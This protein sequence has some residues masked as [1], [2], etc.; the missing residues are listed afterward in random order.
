MRT[1]RID[2]SPGN[3]WGLEGEGNLWLPP[4]VVI[5]W[6][7]SEG[8]SSVNTRRPS[9][10]VEPG[11]DDQWKRWKYQRAAGLSAPMYGVQW[12]GD[13]MPIVLVEDE[14]DALAVQQQADDIC[15]PVATGSTGGAR[16]KR[17]RKLLAN[18]PAV[19]IAFDAE[20]PG[21]NA[22]REWTSALPNAIRWPPTPPTRARC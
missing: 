20:E 11:A 15:R 4:G 5:P 7:D 18:V 1:R 21:E 13:P 2:G 3:E 6:A 9:G 16:R 19:L 10:N 22:A 17:W 12:I 14:F 8:V